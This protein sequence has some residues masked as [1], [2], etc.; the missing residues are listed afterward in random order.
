MDAARSSD[1]PHVHSFVRGLNQ[2]VKAV[3]AAL[4]RPYHNGRTESVNTRTKM[5]SSS[6][7][8]FSPRLSQNRT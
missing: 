8:R 6:R 3:N 5:M 4:S 1:L 2:D 7:G